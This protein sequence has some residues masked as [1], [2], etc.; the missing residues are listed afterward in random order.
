MTV[1][2]NKQT[3]EIKTILPKR[4]VTSKIAGSE[5]SLNITQFYLLNYPSC[6]LD[7][8]VLSDRFGNDINIWDTNIY[9]KK[10]HT[11]RH[12]FLRVSNQMACN[13]NMMKFVGKI[14]ICSRTCTLNTD[15]QSNVVVQNS[16]G[17]WKKACTIWKSPIS[18]SR[19]RCRE[20]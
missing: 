6:L 17:L 11:V 10:K 3:H 12:N 2:C 20:T 16:H 7:N 4:T 1:T 8:D 9:L 15:I 13:R 19:L 18:R 14:K 5:R